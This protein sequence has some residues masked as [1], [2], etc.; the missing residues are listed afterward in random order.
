MSFES[1][2]LEWTVVRSTFNERNK[3]LFRLQLAFKFVLIR[4][5]RVFNTRS[6]SPVAVSIYGVRYNNFMCRFLHTCLKSFPV[7]IVLLSVLIVCGVPFSKIYCSRIFLLFYWWGLRKCMLPAFCYTGRS[8]LVCKI[9]G[10]Q[11]FFVR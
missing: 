1:S 5:F 2:I 4:S 9:S 10:A 3:A 6:T 11:I 8:I 7:K